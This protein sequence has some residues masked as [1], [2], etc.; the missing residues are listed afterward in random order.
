MKMHVFGCV[1]VYSVF[2]CLTGCF[3]AYRECVRM[4][5]NTFG[6]A[7]IQSLFGQVQPLQ[8]DVTDNDETD[9][10]LMTKYGI[11]GPPAILFFDR[12]GNEMRGYRLVGYFAP[13]GFAGHLRKVL[14][15]R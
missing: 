6:E 10:E 9:Q 8:A 4:E 12:Q 1:E 11:I 7:E 5:R 14:A 3:E 13:D 2:E 15:A